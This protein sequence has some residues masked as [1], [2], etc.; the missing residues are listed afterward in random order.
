MLAF[1]SWKLNE[2]DPMLIEA[3]TAKLNELPKLPSILATTAVKFDR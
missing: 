3:P 2:P 1:G